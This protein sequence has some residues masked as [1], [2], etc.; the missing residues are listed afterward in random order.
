MCPGPSSITKHGAKPEQNRIKNL[1]NGPKRLE[2][3]GAGWKSRPRL[4][5]IWNYVIFSTPQFLN[6]KRKFI[7][8]IIITNSTKFLQKRP[9]RGNNKC[10]G[11]KTS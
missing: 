6:P 9:D 7:I 10:V 11:G 1:K 3:V 5:V 8:R 4:Y 2:K